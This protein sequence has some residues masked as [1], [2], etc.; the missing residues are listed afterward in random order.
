MIIKKAEFVTSLAKL[1]NY[2]DFTLPEIAF[3]GRSNVGKSSLINALTGRNKLAKTGSMPGRTRLV[4]YFLVN[5]RFMLVDLPGYGYALASKEAQRE[6]QTLI[7]GYLQQSDNLKMVFV[8]VDIRIAPTDL[9][10]Q[11]LEYLYYYNI[12]FKVIATKV[13]KIAK[14]KVAAQVQMIAGEL[15]LGVAD[16]IA[17]SAAEKQNLGA[18]LDYMS[19]VLDYDNLSDSGDKINQI[20]CAIKE[21]SAAAS[22]KNATAKGTPTRG[23]STNPASTKG[24]K[25]SKRVQVSNL[26]KGATRGSAPQT[27]RAAKTTSATLAARKNNSSS[28]AKQNA[29]NERLGGDTCGKTRQQSNKATSQNARFATKTHS[30]AQNF[31]AANRSSKANE[32]GSSNAKSFAKNVSGKANLNN[33]QTKR[34]NEKSQETKVKHTPRYALKKR[35]IKK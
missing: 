23:A 29:R 17:V 2:V 5:N 16:I 28:S 33:K 35:K 25:T 7:S 20:M 3:V 1:S 13:D 32:S 21:R 12:P 4:N 11:M 8:L 22:T 24:A 30:N 34:N 31:A 14:T 27:S 6:W 19:Q 10:K 15:G 9:D 26:T 18:V